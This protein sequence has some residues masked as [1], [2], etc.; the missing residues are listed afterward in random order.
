MM[1]RAGPGEIQSWGVGLKTKTFISKRERFLSG[2]GMDLVTAVEYL[3]ALLVL[4]IFIF[5]LATGFKVWR[6]NYMVPP[7]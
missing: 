5:I 6:W 4:A 2:V 7:R 3:E 1:G